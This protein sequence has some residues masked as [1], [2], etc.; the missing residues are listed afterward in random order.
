M[1]SYDAASNARVC[2]NVAIAGIEFRVQARTF[3][4]VVAG[5]MK[6]RAGKKIELLTYCTG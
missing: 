3:L 5:S 6:R 1:V 2:E 4:G